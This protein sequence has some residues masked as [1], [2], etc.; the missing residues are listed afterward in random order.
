MQI[1]GILL[2]PR[3]QLEMWRVL[4]QLA[5]DTLREPSGCLWHGFICDS[6]YL[7][8]RD[9]PCSCSLRSAWLGFDVSLA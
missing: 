2:S 7:P 8:V 3:I 6:F 4:D 9:F 5:R 1:L